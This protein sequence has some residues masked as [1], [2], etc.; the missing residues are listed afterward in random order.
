MTS[1][2]VRNVAAQRGYTV[3][4][5]F[6]SLRIINADVDNDAR[7]PPGQE[8]MHT[9]GLRLP[10]VTARARAEYGRL[11]DALDDSTWDDE[12]RAETG[13]PAPGRVFVNGTG[14][15]A[16]RGGGVIEL[17][18]GITVYPAREEHTRWRAVWYEDGARPT[19]R[20]VAAVR[21]GYEY[22]LS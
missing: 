15:A 10:R 14:H 13:R 19:T 7:F 4:W 3:D 8:A 16:T 1:K 5:R 6:I 20:A 22:R 12:L 21:C 9:A 18:C 11:A 2:W 17:E